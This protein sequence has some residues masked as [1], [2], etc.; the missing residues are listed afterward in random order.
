MNQLDFNY[1]GSYNR[2]PSSSSS[3]EWPARQV[4][5]RRILGEFER[6]AGSFGEEDMARTIRV[7]AWTENETDTGE[8]PVSWLALTGTDAAD[9]LVERFVCFH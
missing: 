3:R 6:I 8:N 9:E 1:R 4:S 2:N 7:T 5:Q